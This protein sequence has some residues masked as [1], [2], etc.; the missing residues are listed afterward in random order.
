MRMFPLQILSLVFVVF[1]MIPS[2]ALA[3]N[4]TVQIANDT[5]L[6]PA[7]YSLYVMGYSTS[8]N[9]VMNSSGAFVSQSSGTISSYPVGTGA[10][11]ISQVLIDSNTTNNGARIYFFVVA[12][13][14][15][16]PTIAFGNNPPLSPPNTFCEFTVPSPGAQATVDIQEVDGF[17]MPIT[18]TLNNQINVAGSQFGQ[19]ITSTGQA[20]TIN[21][22]AIFSAYTSFMQ[23]EGSAG[24][25]Y[26]D[27]IL[28]DVYG[29]P[30]GIL[31]PRS[32]LLDA[33]TEGEYLNLTSPL[34]TIWNNALNTL[35]GT[36]GM[37]VQGAGSAAIHGG[38]I[39][40]DKYTVS[41]VTHAYPNS[42]VSLQ[43]LQFTGVAVPANVFYIYNPVGLSVLTDDAGE[44][45]TG[46]ITTVGNSLT[47]TLT[48]DSAASNV[49]ANMYVAGAG[50]PT[51]ANGNSLV[52]VTNVGGDHQTLTVVSSTLTLGNPQANSQY[53]FSKLPGGVMFQTPGQ[54]VFA[55]SGVFAD[56][57][58]QTTDLNASDVLGSLENFLVTALNRGVGLNPAA[59]SPN[60]TPGESSIV[61]GDQTN[62]YPAATIQNL[63][64]AF[65][66]VGT[67][68]GTP[69]FNL[70]VGAATSARGL[71]MGSAYGFPFDE[72][73]GP[74]PAVPNQAQ[75]PPKFDGTVPVGATI[76]VTLG[77]WTGAAPAPAPAPTP[78][79]SSVIAQS[80]KDIKTLNK[81]IKKTK[82]K[83][84]GSEKTQT[85]K[86]LKFAKK[87][88]N[89]V[90]RDPSDSALVSLEAQAMKATKIK[91][92]DQREKKFKKLEKQYQKLT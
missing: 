1:S 42:S 15:P 28:P 14:A 61:W 39:A 22:A 5:G 87:V 74:Q 21:R 89:S 77:P 79:Y 84:T 34:H 67:I 10:G 86:Q 36:S 9:L 30:G 49:A 43:A 44:E 65:M 23:A 46:T 26:L 32:Y 16:A 91:N 51:D 48:L 11:Q 38:T 31:S 56:S 58:V 12:A 40:P 19:P 90:L 24:T 2:L 83:Q 7:A 17:I 33:N 75:V 63:Y 6:D 62:W 59:L 85:I 66:H 37:N 71:A 57:T 78:N 52:H 4:Y 18:I 41:S 55:N 82:K 70:P 20:A 3:D 88:A 81:D 53:R 29:Q 50:I 27:M 64:S 76:L 13:G 47:S 68:G 73:S 8:N 54:M 69:I 72:N 60:S 80:N 92:P 25:P 45:I 35:F